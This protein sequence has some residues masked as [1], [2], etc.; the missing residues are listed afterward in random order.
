MT[1]QEKKQISNGAS[2]QNINSKALEEASDKGAKTVAETLSNF[3]HTEVKV[4]I[5]KVRIEAF[6][7]ISKI[8][9]SPEEEAVIVY[10]QK[11]SGIP[12]ISLLSLTIDEALHLSDLLISKE[13][14]TESFASGPAQKEELTR[15]ALMETL[16]IITNTYLTVVSDFLDT[17][18]MPSVVS[19]MT[20]ERVEKVRSYLLTQALGPERRSLVVFEAKL[21]VEAEGIKPTLVLL[22]VFEEKLIEMIK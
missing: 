17:T 14:E 18:V 21:V 19:V 20:P 3:L 10:G 12:G 7:D 4:Q 5:S 15:S 16:N 9:K 11:L 1:A 22:F 2:M 8:I 6:R 13:K